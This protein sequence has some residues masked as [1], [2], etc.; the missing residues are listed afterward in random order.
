MATLGKL[1]PGTP[2]DLS[3]L[4]GYIQTSD[5]KIPI[6]MDPTIHDQN[7]PSHCI[8]TRTRDGSRMEIGSAWLKTARHGPRAG[9]LFFRNL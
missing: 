8:T 2:D 4:T 9:Q 6:E 5:G 7:R 3:Y 1:M